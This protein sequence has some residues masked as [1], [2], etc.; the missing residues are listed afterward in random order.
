MIHLI[1]LRCHFILDA[2]VNVIHS[3][4]TRSQGNRK[5][6]FH[7]VKARLTVCLNKNPKIGKTSQPLLYLSCLVFILELSAALCWM[8]P[9]A[10][11]HSWFPLGVWL[12]QVKRPDVTSNPL[13][14]PPSESP[15]NA[16]SSLGFSG[17]RPSFVCPLQ[18]Q[19][20]PWCHGYLKGFNWPTIITHSFKKQPPL[21]EIFLCCSLGLSAFLPVPEPPNPNRTWSHTAGVFFLTFFPPESISSPLFGD[22]REQ[23]HLLYI[24]SVKAVP[25]HDCPHTLLTHLAADRAR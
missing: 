1:R 11:W 6:Q 12:G 22:F 21:E 13:V 23:W 8:I 9:G 20:Q 7:C 10:V 4:S 19:A 15:R 17:Y 18:H 14:L 25:R 16:H 3:I 24:C 5:K 2:A